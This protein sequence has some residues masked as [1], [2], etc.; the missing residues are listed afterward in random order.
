VDVLLAGRAR[1]LQV[2]AL[3]AGNL[4]ACVEE[5]GGRSSSFQIHPT[6][7]SWFDILG[8]M[9]L[10]HDSHEYTTFDRVMPTA[11]V[12]PTGDVLK[13]QTSIDLYFS[14]D[15]RPSCTAFTTLLT[16]FYNDQRLG[17]VV[18]PFKVVLVLRC[19]SKQATDHFFSPMPWTAMPHL[20]SMGARGQELVATFGVTKIPALVL[21]D[22][23]RAVVTLD[24]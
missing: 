12:L 9:L 10:L 18:A 22:G 6:T 1:R 24:R 14:A 3:P 2:D 21:L 8:P 17:G 23:N 7:T 11:Q 20:T 13:G 4:C 15:W 5:L 19:K 16:Q